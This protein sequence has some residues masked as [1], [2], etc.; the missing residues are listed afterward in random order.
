MAASQR[1][2]KT[3][4]KTGLDS[5]LTGSHVPGI[6]LPMSAGIAPA[7]MYGAMQRA[8]GG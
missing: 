4:Q 2:Q 7:G 1:E 8:L 3:E 6:A 5:I